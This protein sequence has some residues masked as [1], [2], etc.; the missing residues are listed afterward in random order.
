MGVGGQRDA[1]VA[2]PPGKTPSSHFTGGYLGLGA[3]LDNRC[4]YDSLTESVISVLHIT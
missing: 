2:L 1:P 4:L 3:G